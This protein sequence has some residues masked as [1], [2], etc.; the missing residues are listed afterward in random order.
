MTTGEK[1]VR[2]LGLCSGGLDSML[3][4]LIL[5]NQGIEFI[6]P[7]PEARAKWY[8]QAEPINQK[9]IEAGHFSA[10]AVDQLESHLHDYRARLAR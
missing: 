10:A 3:A 7:P 1:K 5:R 2:G 9:I 8:Q 6:E 4:G